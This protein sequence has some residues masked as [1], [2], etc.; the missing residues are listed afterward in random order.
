MADLGVALE[1][2]LNRL[3]EE[4]RW[5]GVDLSYNVQAYASKRGMNA[6]VQLCVRPLEQ[7][8]PECKQSVA[9]PLGEWRNDPSYKGT[10]YVC[11]DCYVRLLKT[12]DEPTKG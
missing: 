9:T 8:C 4:C 1:R 10:R 2:V 3:V 6:T 12:L 11:P 5:E 7:A